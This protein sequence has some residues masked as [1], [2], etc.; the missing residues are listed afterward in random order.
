MSRQH[1]SGPPTPESPIQES[2]LGSSP[3]EQHGYASAS[4]S[5]HRMSLGSEGYPSWLPQRPPPPAPTSTFQSSFGRRD[6]PSSSEPSH[7]WGGRKPTPRSV[8]I[9]SVPD[10]ENGRREP[11]DQTRVSGGAYTHHARVWSKGTSGG[12]PTS[13]F[14]SATPALRPKFRSKGLHLELLRHPSWKFRLYFYLF[15]IFVFIHIPLQ[16]F[17]DFNAVF[18]LL[19]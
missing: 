15:P 5:P 3:V 17:L 14:S 8:R 18:I 10:S 2:S 11:T 16:T 13:F 19:Q 1:S 12:I 7:M 9:V 6:G 4:T